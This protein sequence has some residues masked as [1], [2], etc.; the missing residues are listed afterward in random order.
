MMKICTMDKF[1]FK[2]GINDIKKFGMSMSEKDFVHKKLEDYIESTSHL[3]IKSP[4]FS[5]HF[6]FVR[7][8]PV[9][10]VFIVMILAGTN[11]Y[12]LSKN[13][14]P[15]D[16]LYPIK[17]NL[18]EPLKY[19]VASTP[20]LKANAHLQSLDNRLREAEVLL[21]QGRLSTDFQAS[22]E[23]KLKNHSE[24]FKNVLS[25][26]GELQEEG[27]AEVEADF[28]A[29]I[30]AHKKILD[31]FSLVSDGK[32]SSRA[33]EIKQTLEQGVGTGKAPVPNSKVMMMSAS[34][35]SEMDTKTSST[36]SSNTSFQERKRNI[37]EIIKN[38]KE[39]IE[40]IKNDSRANQFIIESAEQSLKDAEDAL[41]NADIDNDS[42]D[43]ENALSKLLDSRK[44]AQEADTSIK[45]GQDLDINIKD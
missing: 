43:R 45:I 36:S 4:F 41:S 31:N 38:T 3:K 35:T 2:K 14:L 44:M 22:L 42:G 1:K 25:T 17:V 19:K 20:V 8:T 16:F 13:S 11:T 7:L 33:K 37:V 39:S 27:V 32:N 29:K 21:S 12:V 9:L 26:A 34:V 15:G 5:T 24:S 10:A 6:F 23:S 28:E 40:K 30:N 18:V